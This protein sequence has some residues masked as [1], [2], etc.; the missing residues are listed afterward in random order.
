MARPAHGAK[1][2]VSETEYVGPLPV[3]STEVESVVSPL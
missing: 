2:V 1:H 3:V